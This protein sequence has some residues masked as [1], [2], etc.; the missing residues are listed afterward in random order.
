MSKAESLGR[1]LFSRIFFLIAVL[2]A[3]ALSFGEGANAETAADRTIRT[4]NYF[5]QAGRDL[6][7]RQYD[8]L[9]RYDVLILPM[10][11]AAYNRDFFAYARKKN[12]DIVILAYIPAR[13]INIA[14]IDDVAG[15][16]RQLLRLA[17]SEWRLKTANGDLAAS[18]PNTIPMNVTTGWQWLMPYVVQHTVLS[19]GV[20]DGVFLDEFDDDLLALGD[21]IDLDG[22]GSV[23]LPAEQAARWRAGNRALLMNMRAVIGPQKYIVINGS[24]LP[25]YVPYI[26]GRMFEEFPTP[27]QGAGRW[28]DSMDAYLWMH[29]KVAAP[30]L[31]IINGV[32]R[33]AGYEGDYQRMR[34][35]LGSTLLGDGYFSFDPGRFWHKALW[36]YDEYGIALGRPQSP[37][38]LVGSE[39]LQR[40]RPGIWRRDFERGIVIVNATEESAAIDLGGTYVRFRGVQDPSTNSGGAVDRVII[41]PLDAAILLRTT[42]G[43]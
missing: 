17:R 5:L 33:V 15:Y 30:Q 43:P 38:W 31:F 34:F 1:T 6:S 25:E 7:P 13:S 18:W 23:E 39:G 26:N 29:G 21:N 16:R 36:R 32:P 3:G 42:S 22:D 2:G 35:A 11:S 27:W 10:E 28:E 37:A 9:A 24:S 19:P 14:D 12:P 20:W 4:A 40:I 8:T 41:R